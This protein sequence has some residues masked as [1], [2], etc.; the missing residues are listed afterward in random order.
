MND[1]SISA[2]NCASGAVAQIEN[3]LKTVIQGLIGQESVTAETE[4][5]NPAGRPVILPSESLW[6]AVLIGVL[7][8]FKS[9]RAVWR[10]LVRQ[11]YAVGDQAIYKRLEEEGWQP[12]ARLFERVSQV[13]AQWL[14][15]ALQAYYQ[16]HAMLATFAS[17][18]MAI[19]EMHLD[20]V[21]MRLPILRHF[22]K[23][24]LELLRWP[25]W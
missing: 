17:D 24:D 22:T 12:L 2:R 13:L 6:M 7:R 18:V 20:Q 4:R 19:D 9:M 3:F 23:G 25:C 8:G 5:S 21:K 11:G 16:Q 10:E 1:S 15:P 14:Q